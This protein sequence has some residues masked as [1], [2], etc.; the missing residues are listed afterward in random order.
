MSQ[1]SRG[2]WDGINQLLY[3]GVSALGFV[4]YFAYE[5][6]WSLNRVGIVRLLMLDYEDH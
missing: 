2:D 4:E 1:F 3:L 5:V 6:D